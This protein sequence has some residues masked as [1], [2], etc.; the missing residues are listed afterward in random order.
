MNLFALILERDFYGSYP[1]FH[2]DFVSNP[3]IKD[4][5]HYMTSCYIVKTEWDHNQLSDHCA[6][7]LR[8]ASCKDAHLILSVNLERHQGLLPKSA[9]P[10]ISK[11]ISK[12]R[13]T[14]H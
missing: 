11:T 13:T 9:W 7:S 3:A 4:W 14:G 6:Q 1:K 8:N 2:D 5:W 12:N 10:W